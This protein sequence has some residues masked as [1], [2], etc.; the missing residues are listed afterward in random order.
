MLMTTTGC[1]LCDDAVALLQR[2][3]VAQ[4]VEVDLVE[5]AYD[6]ALLQRYGDRIPVLVDR[7][8]GAELDWPFDGSQLAQFLR[9]CGRSPE[10]SALVL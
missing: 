9:R 2:E 3:L 8:G 5:I 4:A 7:N 1:H 6:E 10:A